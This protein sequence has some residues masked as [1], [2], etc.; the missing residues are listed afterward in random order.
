MILKVSQIFAIA[1]QE[2]TRLKK[3]YCNIRI[4]RVNS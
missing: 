4:G 1:N 2:K 3:L